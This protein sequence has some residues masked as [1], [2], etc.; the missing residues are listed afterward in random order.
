MTGTQPAATTP[1]AV[2][3]VVT[4][5]VPSSGP[6]AGGTSVTITGTDFVTGAT[7]HFGT[8]LAT[9]VTVVSATRI[10]ATS[11]A[12]AGT[13]GVTVTTPGGTSAVTGAELFEYLAAPE[14]TSVSPRDGPLHG[15]TSVTITG[16]GFVTG[17]SAHFGTKAATKVTV[18]GATSITATSPV[19]AGTVGVTVTTPGGTSAVTGAELFEY[20]A[21][22]AVTSVSPRDGP[23]HGGT[24]VTITGTG[25]VTGATVHLG[26]KAAT[27]VTVEGATKITATSPAGTAG[28]VRVTVTTAGGTSAASSAELFEY[29]AVPKVASVSPRDGPLHGGT[30]VTITGTGFV[31]GATVHFGTKQA[32]KVTVESATKITATSPAHAAGSVRVTVTTS[33]GT[34]AASSAD[35]FD[36]LAPRN[37]LRSAVLSRV[38]RHDAREA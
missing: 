8:K 2:P 21:A 23:L 9:K 17:A 13:V 11:P 33:G 22:P 35:L 3:P 12:G 37:G 16:T 4:G 6:T 27:K 31:T 15:G 7:V 14:V 19:G 20:L 1:P 5:V 29:L 18:E 25:F 36:Y 26:T 38:S 34:S 10:T 32:T 24:T 28:S 30:T